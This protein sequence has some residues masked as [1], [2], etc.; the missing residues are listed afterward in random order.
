M[1]G[2]Y[3]EQAAAILGLNK[4]KKIRPNAFDPQAPNR[5]GYPLH[6]E[7][8][9]VR[10][11]PWKIVRQHQIEMVVTSYQRLPEL[12][13]TIHPTA[14][15]FHVDM[16]EG[17]ALGLVHYVIQGVAGL[18][19]GGS[20]PGHPETGKGDGQ[21]QL[22][23]LQALFYD[24]TKGTI[25]GRPRDEFQI[26][27]LNFDEPVTAEDK[28]GHSAY[29]IIPER[30]L[31][32]TTRS[33]TRPQVW[34]WT[35]RIAGLAEAKGEAYALKRDK[36]KK[37]SW[38]DK[39]LGFF[40]AV[41]DFTTA[42]SFEA[43]FSKYQ[44][45]MAPFVRVQD[46][47]GRTRAFLEGW[48]NGTKTFVDYHKA[49][50]DRTATDLAGMVAVFTREEYD[51]RAASGEDL[52]MGQAGPNSRFGGGEA[53]SV[54]AMR[55]AVDRVRFG[56]RVQVGQSASALQAPGD[57]V[58]ARGLDL[59]MRGPA[60]PLEIA[61]ASSALP[62]RDRLAERPRAAQAGQSLASVAAIV[63]PGDTI[64]RFIP[65]GFT[66]FDVIRVNPGLVWPFV[67]GGRLRP[68]GAE[69]PVDP[70]EE[71]VAYIGDQLYVPAT[72]G[73]PP[74]V[75]GQDSPQAARA[76]RL[77]DPDERLFGR[78]LRIDPETRTIEF[79]AAVGDLRTVAGKDNLVQ[80]LDTLCL[81]PIG[82]LTYAPDIGSLILAE[83]PAAWANKIRVQA[84]SLATERTLRQDAAVER[85][86]EVQVQQRNGR[87]V[88]GWT[89]TAISGAALGR[90]GLAV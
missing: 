21:A 19:P 55:R 66:V 56:A 51:A 18:W 84:L 8:R 88:V 82:S 70:R 35:L 76:R 41:D 58:G 16:P 69:R 73:P 54:D 63:R 25:D 74:Q 43:L 10:R 47:I 5:R 57:E 20:R 59:A 65:P 39:I 6:M 22:Y 67:D 80:R 26:E 62:A 15:G 53:R 11:E 13:A 12:R 9:L 72:E 61:A 28:V 85:V 52:T 49:L 36:E 37:K 40:D 87:E 3:L 17:D 32:E 42:Y 68:G 48:A 33:A 31:V 90:S 4:P 45:L 83:G 27:F 78:D 86:D 38:L 2:G 89:V 81:I 46:S 30:S 79:D 64:E 23:A 29:V 14:G 50:F 7:F 71:W 77:D 60:S 34:T 75:S 1:P 24:F 44:R